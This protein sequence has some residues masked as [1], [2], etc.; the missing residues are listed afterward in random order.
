MKFTPL[1]VQGA[2]VVDLERRE[3]HRGFFARIFCV[4]EFKAH[5]LVADIVQINMSFNHKAGT[6]RGLHYQIEP[7]PEAKF[8]RCVHGAVFD[9]MVD[10]RP[11][12]PTY[13]RWCGVELTDENRRAVF[14]PPLCLHGYQALTDGATVIYSASAPYTP[15]AERG[16]RPDDPAFAIQWP[17]PIGELSEKEKAWP[18]FSSLTYPTEGHDDHR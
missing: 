9:V 4:N 6:V 17:L 16:F 3:D 8:I 1:P 15:S 11:D 18:L 13:L 7:A 14:V 5:G 2:F 10:L 12:S